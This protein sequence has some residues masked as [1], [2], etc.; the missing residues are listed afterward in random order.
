MADGALLDD[1]AVECDTALPKSRDVESGFA[2][3]CRLYGLFRH[4]LQVLEV[5]PGL[6]RI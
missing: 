4:D 3:H 5:L 1:A 2:Q 6:E